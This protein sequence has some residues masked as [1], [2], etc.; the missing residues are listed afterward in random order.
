M[1]VSVITV[2]FNN[3][4]GLEATLKSS[5]NQK[6]FDD[7]EIIVIDGGSS[8]GSKDVIKQYE[9][10][11]GY[12]VSEPD[13]GIYNGMNKGIKASRGEYIIF[14]NSGDCFFDDM[15]LWKVFC[16]NKPKSD[17]VCGNFFDGGKIHIM[18]KV[19]TAMY[20]FNDSLCHQAVFLNASMLKANLY[21]ES[22]KITA[23]WAQMF[24]ALVLHDASYEH[25]DAT[26][27]T[28]QDGGV[29]R[30]RWKQLADERVHHKKEV[31]PRR[32]YE[33]YHSFSQERH[34]NEQGRVFIQL[35]SQIGVGSRPAKWVEEFMRVIIKLR[36]IKQKIKF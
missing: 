13:K 32:I 2:N 24:D 30:I 23:D 28:L 19:V 31:L 26:V 5:V 11:I 29:S 10:H 16:N 15:V 35:I 36:E 9:S 34:I 8:D 1:K 33:D 20:M 14:M 6:R 21:D 17:I 18:P 7:F 3:C 4:T 12:W 25:V 27:C 22:Y